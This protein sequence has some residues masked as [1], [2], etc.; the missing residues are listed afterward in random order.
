MTTKQQS[1]SYAKTL[2][3]VQFLKDNSIVAVNTQWLNDG[4]TF[5]E[6]Y[7]RKTRKRVKLETSKL[8]ERDEFLVDP[9]QY[10]SKKDYVINLT[11]KY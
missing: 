10:L 1:D 11:I 7:S 5:C 2:N 6:L 3:A 8:F 9:N 4:R